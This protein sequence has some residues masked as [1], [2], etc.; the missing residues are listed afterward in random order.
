[1]AVNDDIALLHSDTTTAFAAC[2]DRKRQMGICKRAPSA[3][4]RMPYWT[5]ASMMQNLPCQKEGLAREER[6]MRSGS[7]SPTHVSEVA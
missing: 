7:D 1:M 6:C 2:D 5:A 4:D 3:V